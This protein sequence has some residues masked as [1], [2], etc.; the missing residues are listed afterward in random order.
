MPIVNRLKAEFRDQI[1]FIDLNIDDKSLDPIRE[2]YLI[3]GRTQYVLVDTNDEVVKRWF[4][5]L[6][7]AMVYEQIESYLNGT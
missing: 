1:E 7:F 3:T 5:P 4:G 2:K 6:D